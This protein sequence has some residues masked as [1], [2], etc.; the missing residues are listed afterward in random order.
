MTSS[1]NFLDV[2]FTGFIGSLEKRR[3]D[4]RNKYGVGE[5]IFRSDLGRVRGFF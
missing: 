1:P 4:I 5:F 3:G 2:A